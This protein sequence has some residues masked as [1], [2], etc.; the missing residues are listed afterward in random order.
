MEGDP[1]LIRDPWGAVTSPVQ[2]FCLSIGI[3]RII[4]SFLWRLFI[5]NALGNHEEKLENDIQDEEDVDDAC[6]HES[7]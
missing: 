3:E 2:C 5:W 1:T 7:R 4:D 6:A